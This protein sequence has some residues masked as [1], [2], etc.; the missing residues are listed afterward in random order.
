MF[1]LWT[2][3]TSLI[4]PTL[5]TPEKPRSLPASGF[6]T[7]P[8]DQPV[9]EEELPHYKAERFYPVRLGEIF[10]DRYQVLAKL[11]FGTSSTTWLA[12]DMRYI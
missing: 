5:N 9:E 2:T 12:R 6:K 10:Q 7:I 3:I 11:G 4:K 1:S 8:A